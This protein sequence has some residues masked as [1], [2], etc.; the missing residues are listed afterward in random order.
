MPD[1]AGR[2]PQALEAPQMQSGDAETKETVDTLV[3]ALL[4]LALTSLLSDHSFP[5]S[6]KTVSGLK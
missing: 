2:I 1:L 4:Y 6:A 5:T 3:Q